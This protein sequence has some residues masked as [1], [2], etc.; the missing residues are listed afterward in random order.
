MF[1]EQHLNGVIPTSP[2]SV[3]VCGWARASTIWSYPERRKKVLFLLKY[4]FNWHL[5]GWNVFTKIRLTCID[6][7]VVHLMLIWMANKRLYMSIPFVKDRNWF[8]RTFKV[9]KGDQESE[10]GTEVVRGWVSAC[11]S[12]IIFYSLMICGSK[13]LSSIW[14]KCTGKDKMEKWGNWRIRILM[15]FRRMIGS[16]LFL[17]L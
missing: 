3:C 5:N 11:H 15:W 4:F 13:K 16:I 2:M 9:W 8:E 7:A 14:R 10:K 17:I 1:W 6:C 12:I